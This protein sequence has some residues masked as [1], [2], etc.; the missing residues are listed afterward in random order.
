MWTVNAL[1]EA[2]GESRVFKCGVLISCT[3][4]YNYDKGFLPDFRGA[5]SFKGHA[6][7]SAAL[8]G[9]SRLQG[10]E[11]RGDRQRVPPP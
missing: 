3:G 2:S 10:Q 4:Y 8:A 9:K 5:D 11:G 6:Y 1:D 7:P